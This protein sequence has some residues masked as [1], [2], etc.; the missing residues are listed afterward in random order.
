MADFNQIYADFKE[1]YNKS[2]IYLKLNNVMEIEGKPLKTKYGKIL[3]Q[4]R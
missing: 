3:H 1:F 2:P 4:L